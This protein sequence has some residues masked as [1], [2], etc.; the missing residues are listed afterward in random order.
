MKSKIQGVKRTDKQDYERLDG[1]VAGG[2]DAFIEVGLAL[3]EIQERKLYKVGGFK[4][5]DAYCQDR[6]SIGRHRGYQLIKES[7]AAKSVEHV[8]QKPN[9][10][11]S[12]ELAKAPQEVQAEV[13][14][15]VVEEGEPTAAKVQAKVQEKAKKISG[16]TK[17]DPAEIE[18]A[19]ETDADT[20]AKRNRELAH[21]YRDK[22]A[23]A[24]C[25]Y[26]EAAPNRKERDRLVKLVQG[27][28]LW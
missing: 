16:G 13:W 20:L 21:S 11:Q 10:R 26:H 27:V 8:Q 3:A 25:D 22:L 28:K 19:Q 17:F 15:E 24:I 18:S 1:V 9:A 5:F 2:K 7:K 12:A 4:S 14:E 23:R 6:H